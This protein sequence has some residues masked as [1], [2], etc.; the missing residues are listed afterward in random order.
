M[1]L[2]II[3]ETLFVT[4][5]DSPHRSS[6]ATWIKLGIF[7]VSTIAALVVFKL[8][9]VIPNTVFVSPFGSFLTVLALTVLVYYAVIF[10]LA[11]T[12]RQRFSSGT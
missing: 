4:T 9:F 5:G 3:L 7:I 11:R 8:I 2:D 6:R 1:I 12:A 10:L